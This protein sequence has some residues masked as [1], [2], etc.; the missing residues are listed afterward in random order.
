MLR[1][2]RSKFVISAN[3]TDEDLNADI[4]QS[5]LEGAVPIGGSIMPVAFV[6][7]PEDA[8]ITLKK[9]VVANTKNEEGKYSVIPLGAALTLAAV[10]KMTS[11]N[12]GGVDAPRLTVAH[13][14]RLEGRFDNASGSEVT[15]SVLWKVQN[16]P[17]ARGVPIASR[18][19]PF[20]TRTILPT[21][22]M[23]SPV[24]I[25]EFQREM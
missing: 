23:G 24:T 8:N 18:D 15:I 21:P 16:Q 5:D 12:A 19:F 6:L 3:A 25:P 17:S 9:L 4:T 20:A 11:P 2:L 7:D 22:R 1:I 14:A 10:N 13:G